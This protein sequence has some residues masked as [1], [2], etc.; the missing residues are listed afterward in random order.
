MNILKMTGLCAALILAG[1]I[2]ANESRY[3]DVLEKK[4]SF[5]FEQFPIGFYTDRLNLGDPLTASRF[6]N[7]KEIKDWAEMGC[8]LMLSPRF[9]SDDIRQKELVGNI[10]MWCANHKIKMLLSDRQFY[11]QGMKG[12]PEDEYRKQVKFSGEYFSRYPSFFGFM[13]YDEPGKK[14]MSGALAAAKIQKEALPETQPFIN[15]GFEPNY[16]GKTSYDDYFSSVIKG[17][18]L[19]LLSYDIYAQMLNKS[20]ISSYYF[21]V[22]RNLREASIKNGVPFWTILL[23]TPHLYFVDPSLDDIR[24]QFNTAICHGSSAVL[25]WFYYDG[26]SVCANYRNSPI[27]WN[28][29]KTQSWYN[30]R[31]VHLKFH[32]Q[33]GDLFNRLTSTRVTHYPKLVG[34]IEWTPN[35]ILTKVETEI[36]G[37]K[38]TKDNPLLIGEFVDKENRPYLMVV[39]NS[40]NANVAVKLTFPENCKIYHYSKGIERKGNALEF[41]IGKHWL[42]PGQEVVYRI[43]L[44][45]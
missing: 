33:Y 26:D 41:G 22:L 20:G 2:V 40:R 1:N 27:D 25:W 9:T 45:K 10:L 44:A 19:N 3:A 16:V 34:G 39:N 17:G 18:N 15:L 29:N 14:E 21:M 7:D 8:S 11:Q 36:Q 37:Q 42:A 23:A 28:W 12:L 4:A 38:D 30:F 43:E 6:S 5:H 31:Q 32:H 35:T 24:W 13:I